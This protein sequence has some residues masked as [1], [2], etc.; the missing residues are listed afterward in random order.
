METVFMIRFRD[1]NYGTFIPE[2]PTKTIRGLSI[3]SQI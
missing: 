2:K 1:L 3:Q